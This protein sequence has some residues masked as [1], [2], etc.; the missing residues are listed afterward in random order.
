MP[1][2]VEPFVECRIIILHPAKQGARS[3]YPFRLDLPLVI[4]PMKLAGQLGRLSLQQ[5]PELSD[6]KAWESI[7]FLPSRKKPTTGMLL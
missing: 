2:P 7:L 6:Y 1:L 4:I 3:Y 5:R